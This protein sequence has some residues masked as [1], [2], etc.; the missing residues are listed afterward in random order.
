[1]IN[2][3]KLHHNCTDIVYAGPNA[4]A[5]LESIYSTLF[6]YTYSQLTAQTALKSLYDQITY[7]WD[8]TTQSVQG[9]LTAVATALTTA[10]N[11][12]RSAGLAT[13]AEF[14]RTLKGL[15]VLASMN[16]D[17]FQDL[18]NPLGTDV[19]AIITA[20]W[21]G[22]VA[23]ANDDT[24]NGDI[25][26]DL[27]RGLAGNDTLTGD[28]GDD[29]LEGGIGA[30]TL[31]GGSG[32]DTYRFTRGDGLDEIDD[33]DS[34]INA[35]VLLFAAGIAPEDVTVNRG[36]YD[37]YLSYGNGDRITLS[38][39]YRSPNHRIETIRFADS[40]AWSADAA[41]DESGFERNAV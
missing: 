2:K 34:G 22:L 30:D 14:A 10:I 32:N 16:T 33:S 15:D 3:N 31:N 7:G 8:A 28:A 40:T 21:A 6:E 36:P 26:N 41:N 4:A 25:G 18:L 13:L 9:D 23:T 20:S 17:V 1:M 11:S 38:D 24:L 37:L 35:D 29:W 27:L 39:W 5:T 19:T 12:N